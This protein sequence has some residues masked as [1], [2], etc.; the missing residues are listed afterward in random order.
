MAG[1]LFKWLLLFHP[2]F[3]SVAEVDHNPKTKSLEISVRVFTDD[4]EK[5]LRKNFPSSKVDLINSPDKAAMNKL[6]KTY[7]SNHFQ[8][9]VDGKPQTLTYV[10]F[11]K[12]EESIWCY[13]EVPNITTMKKIALH[14]T[15]LYDWQLQQ[16]NMC[17]VHYAGDEKT[18]KLENPES[19]VSFDF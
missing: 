18:R 14:N 9:S 7:I 19:D 6:V 11:E 15:V 16:N 10:G 8:L 5:T 3:V 1:I 13:F 17:I 4:F 12:I 2:F